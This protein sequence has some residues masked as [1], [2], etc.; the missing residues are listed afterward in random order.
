M[1]PK[2]QSSMQTSLITEINGKDIMI[3]MEEIKSE[4]LKLNKKLEDVT[5]RLDV[6]TDLL[7]PEEESELVEYLQQTMA[8]VVS[9]DR[10]NDGIPISRQS[11]ADELD[12]HQNTA[13]I[14]FEKLVKMKKLQK[15][16]GRELGRKQF[17]EKKAVY[18]GIFRTLYDLSYLEELEKRNE[19]AHRI[20]RTLQQQQPLSEKKLFENSSI[21][22]T[23]IQ[24]GFNYLLARGLIIREKSKDLVQYRIRKIETTPEKA[25]TND[26]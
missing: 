12:I 26:Y 5:S 1:K 8:A 14:R 3:T 6:I 24:N 4:I 18:Y 11:L 20:A 23:E 22:K 9:L 19:F 13:Y 10:K 25:T 21:S 17:K 16:Y 7:L 2:P 15:F